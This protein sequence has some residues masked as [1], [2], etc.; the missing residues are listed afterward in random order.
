MIKASLALVRNAQN[1][2]LS[3]SR[4]GKPEALGLPGGKIDAEETSFQAM[5]RETYEETGIRVL[6]ATLVFSKVDDL[7]FEADVWE[8][9]SWEGIP[10][11]MEEGTVSWEEPLSFLRECCPVR[12][13]NRKLFEQQGLLP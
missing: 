3:V 4:K 2:I 1:Q 13:S 9:L 5:V 7:G 11:S 12:D 8:V 10:A 6:R